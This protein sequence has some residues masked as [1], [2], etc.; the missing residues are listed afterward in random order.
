MVVLRGLRAALLPRLTPGPR[1]DFTPGSPPPRG[2]FLAPLAGAQWA[3]G[4]TSLYFT[5]LSF[6]FF[7]NF[8]TSP[9]RVGRLIKLMLASNT[10]Y[11]RLFGFYDSTDLLSNLIFNYSDIY[12]T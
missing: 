2:K 9:W 4:S 3:P 12:L 5:P 6:T 1:I 10:L 8:G 7:F 11:A